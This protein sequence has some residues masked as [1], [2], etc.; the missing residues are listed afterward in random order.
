MALSVTDAALKR[1]REIRSREGGDAR[2]LRLGVRGGGCSG[3]SYVMDFV[4]APDDTD[5][6]FT[7]GDDV[8]VCVDKKSYLFLNGVELDYEASLTLQR[9]VFNNPQA[10]TT[11]S[12]GSSFSV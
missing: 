4:D 7:F 5:K 3:F 10:E 1:V 8:N 11:C 9:F 12:C 6:R 2:W